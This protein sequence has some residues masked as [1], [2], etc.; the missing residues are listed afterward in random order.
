ME[1]YKLPSGVTQ[2]QALEII[3]EAIGSSGPSIFSWSDGI[4]GLMTLTAD[5]FYYIDVKKPEKKNRTIPIDQMQKFSFSMG[6]IQITGDFKSF[7]AGAKKD[8]IA[9]LKELAPQ[10]GLPIDVE[11]TV[12]E[13]INVFFDDTKI[14]Y[15]SLTK[16]Y[17][18][19]KP[20]QE[21]FK[22]SS[23]SGK[24]PWLVVAAG[25]DGA[26]AAYEDEL[27]IAKTGAMTGFMSS[28]TGG[29][30]ITHFPY[31]QIVAFTAGVLEVLTASYDG[32]M[33]K[34]N[35]GIKA[36]NSSGGDPRQQN[37]TLP[38]MK[39]TYKELSSDLNRIRQLIEK[40]HEVKISADSISIAAPQI[41]L[42]AQIQKLAELKD[43]GILSVEEFESAKQ[44][45]L[46][47]I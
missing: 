12:N 35:W 11:S 16:K 21:V 4:S 27:I 37:N 1:I 20:S 34:D 43:S 41:D 6:V 39:S 47:Q 44:K 28:A 26:L 8:D 29:G 40:S 32:G 17:G 38:I 2:E 19:N 31:R 22:S 10:I 36:P 9:K 46:G 18:F 5:T 23:T 25:T 14:V 33:N 7:S 42:I 30:R 15:S 24:P 45:L 3:S 13:G